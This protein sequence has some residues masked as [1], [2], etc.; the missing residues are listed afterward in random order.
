MMRSKALSTANAGM[1]RL[2]RKGNAS[3]ATLYDCLNAYITI[4]GTIKPRPGT[5]IDID[6]PPGTK[7]LV[8]HKG[9]MN[10]FSHS[11]VTIDDDRYTCITLRHPTDPTLSLEEIHFAKP[12]MGFLYVVASFSD[13][14]QYHYWAEDLDPWEAETIYSFNERVFPTTPN[15]FA[16][17]ATRIGSPAPVWSAGVERTVGDIIEPTVNNGYYYECI[18]TSGAGAASG[19]I[20]P[21]WPTEEGAIIVEESLGSDSESPPPT[22]GDDGTD[23]GDIDDRYDNPNYGYPGLV[24]VYP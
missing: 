20:E 15:G 4:A 2:R 10:V 18:A 14:S 6:L 12:F 1:T 23:L 21:I 7:G 9:I 8:A 24:G 22:P 5:I 16:Y 3:P 19:D 11:P 13:G 17:K